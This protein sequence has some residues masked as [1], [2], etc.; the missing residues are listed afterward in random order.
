[1]IKK[2]IFA[3]I[4]LGIL[5]FL[6]W[7][8]SPLF[9]N[10]EVQDELDPELAALLEESN[11]PLP[12]APALNERASTDPVVSTPTESA[13]TSEIVAAEPSEVPEEATVSVPAET[14]LPAPNAQ[15]QTAV[16]GPFTITDTPGHPAE[17]SIRVIDS[18]EKGSLVRFEEYDGTNG[19]DLRIYLATDLEATEF[20]D[21]GAAKG[22]QGNINYDVPSDVDLDDYQYVLTW[23]RAFGV[24]FDY[25]EI[26]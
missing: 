16:R 25:A 12:T 7:T 11:E 1:M 4:G 26:N 18:P 5:A 17:G 24:L 14:S 6:W 8:I 2:I 20:V 10:N 13:A 15:P 9:I 19:P 22:N 3:I 21:L 23:C